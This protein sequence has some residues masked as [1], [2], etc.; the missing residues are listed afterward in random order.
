[1]Y[2]AVPVIAPTE[3]IKYVRRIHP[4]HTRPVEGFTLYIIPS[5]LLVAYTIHT[6]RLFTRSLLPYRLPFPFLFSRIIC[7]AL[8]P[9]A[10]LPFHRCHA[11]PLPLP[12]SLPLGTPAFIA[13]HADTTPPPLSSPSPPSVALALLVLRL[14][15]P[16]STSLPLIHISLP[17]CSIPALTIPAPTRSPLRT[18][19][20]FCFRPSL[21]TLCVSLWP[22]I[23]HRVS[24]RQYAVDV[25]L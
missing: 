19:H 11:C 23:L 13:P 17:L 6:N 1:M 12:A 4:R 3:F 8:Y 24:C 7:A 16:P 18:L 22:P 10:F 9:L 25:S 21:Y 2:A 15:A 5:L 14:H 20:P